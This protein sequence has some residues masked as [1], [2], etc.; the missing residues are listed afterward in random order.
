LN[1]C[2]LPGPDLLKSLVAI[3]L[4]FRRYTIAFSSDVREMFHQ[5]RIRQEDW[6]AQ[7]FLWRNLECDREPD[8]YELTVMTFGATCSPVSAQFIKNLN[9]EEKSPN[10]EVR[11]T[12]T[13]KFYV[14]DYI[15]CC[16]NESDALKRITTVMDVMI[17][18]RW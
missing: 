2:L 11:K 12:I 8:V 6:C 14:D 4:N 13:E 17:H 7:R 10:D 1:D 5:V 3:L 15:D 18:L 16:D 9:A